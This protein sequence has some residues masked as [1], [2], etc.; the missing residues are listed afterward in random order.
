MIVKVSH[1]RV[2]QFSHFSV[3]EFLTVDW[4]A[5]LMRR[6]ASRHHIRL[7]AAHAIPAQACLGVLLRLDDRVPNDGI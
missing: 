7:E 3:E 6:D 1:S 4:L 2:V 5:E